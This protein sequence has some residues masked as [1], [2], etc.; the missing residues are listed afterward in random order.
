MTKLILAISPDLT[1][2]EQ[3]SAHLQEGGRFQVFTAAS[4][5]EALALAATQPFNLTI[6]DA[7]INDLPFIPL[8]REL[9][10]LLP[11]LKMLVYPPQNNPRHPVLSGLMAN[12]FLNKPFFGPEVNEKIL[13]ALNDQDGAFE[14]VVDGTNLPRLWLEHPESGVQQV[15]Q[16]LASTTASA[17]LLL[18]HGQVIAATGAL[19]DETSQNVVNFLTRYWTNIQA[20]ELFRYLNMDNETKTYLVYATP[21]FKDV[22]LALIYHTNVSLLDIRDEVS[23]I[24]KSF[25]TRYHNTG[26]LRLEFTPLA[27]AQPTSASVPPQSS[28]EPDNGTTQQLSPADELQPA[29]EETPPQVEAAEPLPEPGDHQM[30]QPEL[31]AEAEEP[32]HTGPLAPLESEVESPAAEAESEEVQPGLSAEE[33]QNLDALLA[34]MPEPDPE[35]AAE[36]SAPIENPELAGDWQVVPEGIKPV[37]EPQSH[38]DITQPLPPVAESKQSP[39]Q[40]A[41]LHSQSEQTQPIQVQPFPDFNFKLPWEEGYSA[42]GASAVSSKQPAPPPL[43]V[44]SLPE[45]L[46]EVGRSSVPLFEF[47]FLILPRLPQQFLTHELTELLNQQLPRLHE[48]CGWQCTRISVRPLYLQWAAIL[49][50]DLCIHEVV[51]EIKSR[52]EIQIFANFP[53]LLQTHP[54]GEFWAPGYFAISGSHPISNRMVN[55]YLSLS[56]QALTSLA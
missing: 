36:E 34:G 45:P 21:L 33:L 11:G 41:P 40:T 14:A 6:L 51:Q 47:Q 37:Q 50:S 29:P 42:Q 1:L 32:D 23:H 4:G 26:E 52:S 44:M 3:I 49:P 12:G 5:K 13:H 20:G 9:V 8:T 56:R 17:G 7:E 35:A 2:L 39:G 48:S 43:P 25:L 16:L 28:Q 53:G 22:A 10:A 30:D 31:A 38:A 46:E 18:M 15:E 55:D 27:A 24:R 54:A 19:A